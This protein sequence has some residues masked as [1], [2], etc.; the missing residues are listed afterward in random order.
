MVDRDELEVRVLRWWNRRGGV[1]C[2]FWLMWSLAWA[3]W[4][5]FHDHGLWALA[6][7]GCAIWW[8]AYNLRRWSRLRE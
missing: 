8:H 5:L 1:W 3:T 7:F 2:S 4:E 6:L